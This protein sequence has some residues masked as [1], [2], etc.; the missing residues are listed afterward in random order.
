MFNVK[1][2]DLLLSACDDTSTKTNKIIFFS[3]DSFYIIK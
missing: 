1:K 3:I 2:I